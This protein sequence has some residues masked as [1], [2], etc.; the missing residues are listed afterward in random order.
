MKRL[1]YDYFREK[2]TNLITFSCVFLSYFIVFTLYGLS[3]FYYLYPMLLSLIAL[4]T[5]FALSFYR[6][7]SK[8]RQRMQALSHID[9]SLENL[10]EATNLTEKDYMLLLNELMQRKNEALNQYDQKTK[11]LYEY[12]TLWSHQMKTPVT[13]MGLVVQETGGEQAAL[14]D[15][16][17]FEM[18]RYIDIL[19]QFLR[20]DTMHQDLLIQEYSL[21][22]IV[23]QAV[24]YFSRTFIIKHISLEMGD[25][26]T[27]VVT[28]EKWLLFC[29]K[30]VLSNSLKYTKEGSVRIYEEESKILVIEDTGIGISP[31][32]LPRIFEQGFTG[33]NGHKDK[34]A[35]GIGLYLTKK[36]MDNLGHPIYV[37]SV[38]GQGTKVMF[39]LSNLHV[40]ESLH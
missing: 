19:L 23:K 2:K 22:D 26:K 35:T 16:Q 30:Q 3:P 20:L 10:P 17:L 11:E 39:H 29:I 21:E 38:P 8:H 7:Q 5:G 28:D 37:E 27:P 34:C 24:K 18:N 4:L 1:L 13:A 15:T 40:E 31:E 14:L 6:Y 9:I 36:I 25:L 12:A 33:Y 32:D